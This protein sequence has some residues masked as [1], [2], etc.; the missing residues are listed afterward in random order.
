MFSNKVL[1]QYFRVNTWIWS[2]K[3]ATSLGQL[4]YIY[5]YIYIYIIPTDFLEF[6]ATKFNISLTLSGSY[7]Q[8]IKIYIFCFETKYFNSILIVGWF[9]FMAYQ[10]F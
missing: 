10:L 4:I 9:G 8:R 6:V 2:H 5:I 7:R 3:N 1:M